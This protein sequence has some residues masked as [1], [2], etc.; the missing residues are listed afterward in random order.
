MTAALPVAAVVLAGLAGL[1]LVGPD[2]VSR[3]RPTAPVASASLPRTAPAGVARPIRVWQRRERDAAALRADL[4]ELLAAMGPELR[5]GSSPPDAI[6][7][8]ARGHP[9]LAGLS[10]AA[11]SPTGDLAAALAELSEQPGGGLAGR[12]RA[13]VLVAEQ[14]G[15]PLAGPVERLHSA[16]RHDQRLRSEVAAQ[17]AGPRLTARLLAGLPV[18]GILLG[19]GMGAQPLDFLLA[20]GPGLVCSATGACLVATGLWWTG[21]ISD[22]VTASFTDGG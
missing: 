13:A 9:R 3:V 1:L 17:L 2:A 6:A 8:A 5:A 20:T 22:S 10:E 18:V 4:A 16:A 11:R 14:V 15:C 7:A 21:R 19:T 12:L